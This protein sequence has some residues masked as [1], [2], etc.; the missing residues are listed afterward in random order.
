[1]KYIITESK[2]FNVF[3]KY[4]EKSHPELLSL[5]HNQKKTDYG[6]YINYYNELGN[7]RT[8]LHYLSEEED[9]DNFRLLIV[10][11]SEFPSDIETMFGRKYLSFLKEWFESVYKLPVDT[12]EERI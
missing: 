11:S 7:Y 1:M 5:T 3:S 6:Y 4:I 9:G 10:K 2:M 8:I 12:I